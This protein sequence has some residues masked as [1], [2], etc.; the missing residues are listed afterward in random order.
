MTTPTFIEQREKIIQAY[1]RDEIRPFEVKFCFCGT[2]CDNSNRWSQYNLKRNGEPIHCDVGLYKA[3]DF[4]KMEHALL[5]KIQAICETNEIFDGWYGEDEVD[6]EFHP[7][8]EQALFEGM[9][10]ALEIL[11]QIH[12]EMGDETAIEI[13]LVKRQLA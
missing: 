8:Y 2:L 5:I 9:C 4:I 6:V 10:D 7:L 11:R 12:I 3:G 1:F 13:P